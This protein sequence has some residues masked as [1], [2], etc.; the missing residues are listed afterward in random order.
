MPYLPEK[1]DQML[2]RE[3]GFVTS[4]AFCAEFDLLNK[5]IDCSTCLENDS[6][7]LGYA[8]H[9]HHHGVSK[10]GKKAK[11]P[12]IKKNAQQGEGSPKDSPGR[13]RRNQSLDKA[14]WK[15]SSLHPTLQSTSSDRSTSLADVN[16]KSSGP[17][18]A[19]S[20]NGSF[21]LSQILRYIP[22][23]YTLI[24]RQLEI[25]WANGALKATRTSLYIIETGYRIFDILVQLQWFQA[26]SKWSWI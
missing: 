25:S 12:S 26:S 6:V 10:G 16:S 5:T 13:H 22:L 11:S 15:D 1:K 17:Y 23:V 24:S 19:S 8:Q 14:S 3:A 9:Q 4:L 18:A 7:C 20:I 2:W 21:P